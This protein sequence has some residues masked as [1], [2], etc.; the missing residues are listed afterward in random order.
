MLELDIDYLKIDGSIIKKLPF[1]ENARSVVQTIVEFANRQKYDVVAGPAGNR[2]LYR[3]I[4]PFQIQTPIFLY[5][6][7]KGGLLVI[8]QKLPPTRKFLT[9]AVKNKKNAT[10]N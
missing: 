10:P 7:G 1:D 3:P 2:G 8:Y 9:Q 4:N 5:K 6:K